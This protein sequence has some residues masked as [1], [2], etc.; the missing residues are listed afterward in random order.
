MPPKS[1]VVSD[2]A[3]SQAKISSFFS[4]SSQ[5]PS[6]SPNTP[7]SIAVTPEQVRVEKTVSPPKDENLEENMKSGVS[8][9][10]VAGVARRVKTPRPTPKTLETA[11]E[12]RTS[13]GASSNRRLLVSDSEDEDGA[14]ND[15]DTSS[16][17]ASEYAP[18]DTEMAVVESSNGDDAV[19]DVL[20]EESD[21]SIASDDGETADEKKTAK[22]FGSRKR[23]NAPTDKE[24]AA[25]SAKRKRTELYSATRKIDFPKS[26]GNGKSKSSKAVSA[27][28]VVDLQVGNAQHDPIFMASELDQDELE[29]LPGLRFDLK[30]FAEKLTPLEQVIVSLKTDPRYADVVLFVECGY[31]YRFFGRDA[32]IASKELSIFMHMDKNFQTGSIPVQ[33]LHVHIRRLCNLGYKCAT[34]GQLETRA[35]KQTSGIFKRGITGLFTKGTLAQ[36]G[37]DNVEECPILLL[38]KTKCLLFS[39]STRQLIKGFLTDYDDIRLRYSPQEI[40]ISEDCPL[41]E[42]ACQIGSGTRLEV[43]SP[44]NGD[45]ANLEDALVSY[46][47]DFNLEKA[48]SSSTPTT[49][50]KDLSG[51]SFDGSAYSNLQ[52]D[53]FLR[54][55]LFPMVS[56]PMGKRRLKYLFAHP[57]S[58]GNAIRKKISDLESMMGRIQSRD[59]ETA[60]RVA[61]LRKC[62]D[63]DRTLTKCCVLKCGEQEFDAFLKILSQFGFESAIISGLRADIRSIDVACEKEYAPDFDRIKKSLQSELEEARKTLRISKLEYTSWLQTECLFEIER[64]FVSRVPKSWEQVSAT[65]AVVRYHSAA[66]KKLVDE[67]QAFRDRKEMFRQSKWS[68]FLDTFRGSDNY[69]LFLCFI[70]DLAD[71]DVVHS[72]AQL[73][74]S[75]G[76]TKPDVLVEEDGSSVS[77]RLSISGGRHPLLD[78]ATVITNDVLLKE[79]ETMIIT[80]PN[81]GGKSTALRMVGWT[82]LLAHVGCFVPAEKCS[83]G[84]FDGI[85]IRMGAADDINNGKST[86]FSELYET[87]LIIQGSSSRSLVIFD[88]LGRGTSTHDGMAIAWAVADFMRTVKKCVTLFVTHFAMLSAQEGVSSYYMGFVE[89]AGTGTGATADAALSA[90]TITFLYKLVPGYAPRSFGLNV[91]VLAGIP[92]SV[93]SDAAGYSRALETYTNMHRM[94]AFVSASL[95]ND[96]SRLDTVLSSMA[97]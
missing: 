53:E 27:D 86:F 39:L 15:D 93:V 70:R 63:L 37:D 16:S 14:D 58:N 22:R 80:G 89:N 76:L 95:Q 85:F 36:L 82:V 25:S 90:D 34:V 61:L 51:F 9:K 79:G 92:A 12:K 94:V 77:C 5:K 8:P 60:R 46:L 23:S 10:L 62:G 54:R 38:S 83:L 88:E 69:E 40:L 67:L 84:V 31:R 19:D 3:K 73:S 30:K 6:T 56:S 52:V 65:K 17:H 18:S 28:Q 35:L 48:V 44:L 21:S 68:S 75:D 50:L 32:L 20:D 11:K 66:V 59:D 49:T 55:K 42:Q 43:F 45:P 7:A 97:R 33:R 78:S 71:E 57:L 2:V 26:T 1:K 74:I 64:Q 24:A 29:S 13:K 4:P 72:F 91:A 87:S 41:M 47:T 96:A 81:L